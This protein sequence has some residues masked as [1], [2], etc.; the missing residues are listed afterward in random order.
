M[1]E[2]GRFSAKL[3]ALSGKSAKKCYRQVLQTGDE[4]AHL[5]VVYAKP[6]TADIS[7]GLQWSYDCVG[8]LMV[9]DEVYSADAY[10]VL[11][12]LT[13]YLTLG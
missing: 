4:T 5:V 8:R 12:S 10:A 3:L 2:K 11:D 9:S 13:R 7:R 6:T 1:D